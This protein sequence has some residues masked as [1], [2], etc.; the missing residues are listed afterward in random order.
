MRNDVKPS[1]FKKLRLRLVG[2]DRLAAVCTFHVTQGDAH[3]ARKEWPAA[4]EHYHQALAINPALPAIWV[5]L[6][7]GQ[8]EIG[9]LREAEQ[10]YMRAREIEPNSQ[11]ASFFLRLTRD[12]ISEARDSQLTISHSDTPTPGSASVTKHA[13]RNVKGE[14][15][16]EAVKPPEFRFS[17]ANIPVGWVRP[18]DWPAQGRNNVVDES[19]LALGLTPAAEL[20]DESTALLRIFQSISS[21]WSSF[22]D[23]MRAAG[24]NLGATLSFGCRSSFD[25]SDVWFVNSRMLR[26]RF[27]PDQTIDAQFRILRCFQ[28]DPRNL[29]KLRLVAEQ[30]VATDIPTFADVVLM[31]PYFP[32]LMSI[33]AEHGELLALAMMPFPSLC[34]GGVHFGELLAWGGNTPYRQALD[35]FGGKLLEAALKRADGL[36]LQRIEVDLDGAT[37]TERIFEPALRAWLRDI[38]GTSIGAGNIPADMPD[39]VR[40][41]LTAAITSECDVA[42][43]DKEKL[44]LRVPPDAVP[45]LRSI[46]GGID[47]RLDGGSVPAAFVLASTLDSTPAWLVTPPLATVCQ[48]SILSFPMFE[49]PVVQITHPAQSGADLPIAQAVAAIRFR[50]LASPDDAQLLAPSLSEANS[51]D[52]DETI[53]PISV[54]HSFSGDLDV[55]AALLQSLALQSIGSKLDVLVA[56]SEADAQI[57]TPLLSR[58]F[59]G[60]GRFVPCPPDETQG[61]RLARAAAAAEGDLLLFI[62]DAVLFHD[63]RTVAHLAS[64]IGN[65]KVASATCMLVGPQKSQKGTKLG[66]ISSGHIPFFEHSGQTTPVRYEDGE[67]LLTLPAGTWPVALSSSRLFLV[68]KGDWE[69]MGVSAELDDVAHMAASFCSKSASEG[70]CHLLS[71]AISASLLPVAGEPP[72]ALPRPASSRLALD[73]AVKTALSVRRLVA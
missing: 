11:D 10:S 8:R 63:G 30:P 29:Q 46:T 70:L 52:L 51:G 4:I 25:L 40:E 48:A 61:A 69:R 47:L 20:G 32:L 68:R 59:S 39:D 38:V 6:G 57:V 17:P 53:S 44:L 64:L 62:A 37:G 43:P 15:P 23:E 35:E 49:V 27:E 67:V 2:R 54:V 73:E 55:L 3:N 66:L 50:H 71:T 65:A 24:T 21:P 56:G 58:L 45:S 31:N 12:L 22:T 13:P 5:Q 16:C 72:Q 33:S 18:Q 60:R 28:R 19:D 42:G 7:H 1:L 14:P 9:L 36:A 26:L 41:Y 34:R